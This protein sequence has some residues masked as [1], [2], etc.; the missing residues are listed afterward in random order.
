MSTDETYFL[1]WK[2]RRLGPWTLDEI[3]NAL[4]SDEVHSLYQIHAQGAW[5]PLREF[6][7]QTKS[8]VSENKK[9]VDAFVS[10]PL[11]ADRPSELFSGKTFNGELDNRAGSDKRYFI[12]SK[13]ARSGPFAED[14]VL[15]MINSGILTSADLCW[16]E[17]LTDWRPLDQA[18]PYAPGR[19]PPPD[20]RHLEGHLSIAVREGKY[21]GFWLRFAAHVLDV[22]IT[23]III[24]IA[25]FML[26]LVLQ[27]ST[28]FN[29]NA[30]YAL[31]SIVSVVAGWLYYALMESGPKQATLGKLALG[32]CVTNMEGKR[33]SFA[34]ATGRYFGMIV[35]SL[36]LG[37]GFGMCA[38]TKRK[39]CLHDMMAGCIMHLK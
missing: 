19:P 24:F 16:H 4:R 28:D 39:Q 29:S 11:P 34:Q 37:V 6:L 3:E 20:P 30:A 36:T 27:F 18:L 21:A 13:G 1:Q 14:Q 17:G 25:V 15:S 23:N 9:Q 26:I 38:W 8:Q 35:S 32:F 10:A 12:T 31:S 2:G 22:L 33:I 5:R 7:E